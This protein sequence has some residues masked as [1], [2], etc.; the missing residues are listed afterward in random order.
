MNIQ[1]PNINRSSLQ[2][3]NNFLEATVSLAAAYENALAA[4]VEGDE[5]ETRFWVDRSRSL[6]SFFKRY[7][8]EEN[9][10][11]LV[12][13]LE[14]NGGKQILVNSLQMLKKAEPFIGAWATRFKSLNIS[15]FEKFQDFHWNIFLD[16]MVPLT[17][18]WESDLFI[19]KQSSTKIAETLLERGQR[20]IILIEPNKVKKKKLSK[21]LACL[22]QDTESVYVVPAKEDLKRIISVWIDNPPNLSR[23]IASKVSIAADDDDEMAAIQHIAR[24]GMINALTFDCTI[25][26]HDQIWIK[27]GIGNFE[28]LINH[29][30]VKCLYNKFKDSSVIIVSPGPSL[31]KNVDRLRDAKG[32]AIIVAVSHSLEFLKS[33]DIIPDVILHVDPN[34]NIK[35]YFEGFKFEE[36]ELLILSSTTDPDLFN[37]PTRNKAWLYANG[38][39]DNWLMQLVHEEDYTLWGSCVSVAA[40]KLAYMWGCK[41][42]ALIGQDLSFEKGDYYAGSTYAPEEIISSF[43][44]SVEAQ[45][46]KLPGYYGGEVITK[47]DYRLYHGQFEDVAEDIINRTKI[48]LYNCTEG[49][50]NIKGFKNCTLENF[51]SSI[52]DKNLGRSSRGAVSNRFDHIEQNKKDFKKDLNRFLIQTIDKAKVRKTIVKTK[53]HLTETETLLKAALKKVDISETESVD[54]TSLKVLQKKVAKKLKSSLVLKIKLQDSLQD[55][56]S[57]EG[58]EHNQRG[59]HKK[60]VDMYKACIRVV[61][62]LRHDLNELNLR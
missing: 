13:G 44:A 28:Q 40:L 59:N 34:V 30:N 46:M 17:W 23:V 55:I 1:A 39:F 54:A 22:K 12:A 26:S 10:T 60:M 20:R 45:E 37:L 15:D 14:K 7:D 58:Y 29:P 11:N 51:I 36:V 31:E 9:K 48:N 16:D 5:D 42:I 35:K 50:A 32:K 52:L 62:E 25:Q 53:R 2:K 47:N 6:K 61:R 43:T 27:N 8:G 4:G 49:G 33:K 3:P 18:D 41:N 19:I 21:Y 24:E 38:Y 57:A 56:S